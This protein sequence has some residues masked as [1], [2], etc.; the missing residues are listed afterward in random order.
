M[1]VVPILNQDC[2]IGDSWDQLLF[3]AIHQ[4][5]SAAVQ[6]LTVVALRTTVSTFYP[7]K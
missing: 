3:D 6:L 2:P 7:H 5:V 1:H 4:F